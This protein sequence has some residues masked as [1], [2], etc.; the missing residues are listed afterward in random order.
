MV[1]AAQGPDGTRQSPQT[2]AGLPVA[3]SERGASCFRREIAPCPS[4]PGVRCRALPRVSQEPFQPQKRSCQGSHFLANH[5]A[6]PGAALRRALF[7]RLQR[8]DSGPDQ[9]VWPCLGLDQLV[10]P[11]CGLLPEDQPRSMTLEIIVIFS[12]TFAGYFEPFRPGGLPV[13]NSAGNSMDCQTV[14][15]KASSTD[16]LTVKPCRPQ[17][18]PAVRKCYGSE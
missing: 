17:H 12:S 16:N 18:R 15:S 7:F 1:F 8:V 5:L 4:A 2:A 13:D 14:S 3:K 10:G 11:S 6:Q 9:P